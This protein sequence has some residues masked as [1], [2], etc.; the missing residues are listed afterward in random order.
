MIPVTSSIGCS[1]SRRNARTTRTPGTP[2]R[3]SATTAWPTPAPPVDLPAAGRA[4][5]P[6]RGQGPARR[7]PGTRPDPRGSPLP[8]TTRR[9]PPPS[10]GAGHCPAPQPRGHGGGRVLHALVPREN[11]LGREMGPPVPENQTEAT[12]SPG[13]ILLTSSG[14]SGQAR[15]ARRDTPSGTRTAD[16][17]LASWAGALRRT[18]RLRR[19]RGP[20]AGQPGRRSARRYRIL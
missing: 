8:A 6:G 14:R 5:R 4:P 11:R 15:R 17:A 20:G 3:C 7:R 13:H 9:S 16:L 1:R 2:D 19:R 18:G 12:S 10:R